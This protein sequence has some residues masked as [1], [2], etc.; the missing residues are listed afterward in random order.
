MRKF[1]GVR[2]P[3]G[4]CFSLTVSGVPFNSITMFSPSCATVGNVETLIAEH[5]RGC[6][7][8]GT[9]SAMESNKLITFVASRNM[10]GTGGGD[11]THF[12]VLCRTSLISTVHLPGGL[13][14]RG[15]GARI[16]D[17]LVVLRGGA[18]G[19]SLQKSSGLLSAICGSRGH[20]PAGGCFL[21]RPRHVVRAAT[22]LSAS[23][24][25]G[26]TVVCARRS[27]IRNVTRSLQGVLRRS[28]GGGL[29]LGQCLKVRRAVSRR[30]GRIRRARGVRG[31]RG[32]GPSVRMGRGSAMM[33]LRGRRGPASSTRLSR[34]S[35][36][37]RPPI[38]VALFSL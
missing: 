9:L 24:F 15:T 29:G 32:V 10:L 12:V 2:G 37:R 1:R 17:S 34:G 14:A 3:F 18:R 11:T 36:R 5:V 33:S 35:G 16:N 7:F 27:N 19:R 20:V 22:G 13:F 30:I 26:P 28:F 6:F 21:R 4:S 25:N 23:P 8:I 38:R 31:A